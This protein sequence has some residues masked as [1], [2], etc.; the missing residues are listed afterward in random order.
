[1]MP[2]S[3]VLR[4]ALPS[5][6]TDTTWAKDQPQYNVLPSIRSTE[7]GQS[8]RVT[9]RWRLTWRERWKLLAGGSLF[10]Q[11][12]TFGMPLQP[13]LPFVGEPTLEECA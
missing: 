8:G 4:R 13:L 3:P 11:I 12:L 6:L 1:M 5:Y 10:I 7:P 9:T 2:V